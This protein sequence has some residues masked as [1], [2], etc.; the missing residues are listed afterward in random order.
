MSHLGSGWFADCFNVRWELAGSKKLCLQIH[1]HL[2]RIK[3]GPENFKREDL[4][5][6]PEF[7]GKEGS[8]FG[9]GNVSVD[10]KVYSAASKTPGPSWSGPFTAVKLL[11][12]T[13][14]GHSWSRVDREGNELALTAMGSMRNVV[15]EQEMFSLKEH[16]IPHQTQE[17]YPFSFFDFV[18]N[19]KDNSTAKD[20]YVYIY[21]P[22]GAKAHQLTLARVP[23]DKIGIRSEWQYF[24][25]YD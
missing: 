21:S 16:G 24:T 11:K 18:Q 12:S 25:K 9:Y 5:N 19:S 4:P 2:Y 23:H 17:A 7:S 15:N 3:G 14:N 20:E 8:W 1:N 22:E 6:Y 10:G 13:D